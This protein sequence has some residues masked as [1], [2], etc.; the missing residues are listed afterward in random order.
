MN[1]SQE[2][3]SVRVRNSKKMITSER[4]V[5]MTQSESEEALTVSFHCD[6]NAWDAT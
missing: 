2:L 1:L 5:L 4:R 3:S 6:S